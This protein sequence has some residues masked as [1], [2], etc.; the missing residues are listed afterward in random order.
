MQDVSCKI[1]GLTVKVA[2]FTTLEV[3]MVLY[4]DNLSTGTGIFNIYFYFTADSLLLQLFV[5]LVRGCKTIKT[6]NKHKL[7]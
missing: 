1:F 7:V 2:L 6:L 5:T 3:L 4:S